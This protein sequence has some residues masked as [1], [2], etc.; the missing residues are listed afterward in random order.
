MRSLRPRAPSPQPKPCRCSRN[1]NPKLH[2]VRAGEASQN[3]TRH[4]ST[5]EAPRCR[6]AH[7]VDFSLSLS[8]SPAF[9]LE[10]PPLPYAVMA[11]PGTGCRCFLQWGSPAEMFGW[12][13]EA[14]EIFYGAGVASAV[15]AGSGSVACRSACGGNGSGNSAEKITHPVRESPGEEPVGPTEGCLG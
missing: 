10:R 7:Q 12:R 4:S 13:N 8:L 2:H 6:C 1:R 14:M 9:R 11:T 15:H 5:T 3:I